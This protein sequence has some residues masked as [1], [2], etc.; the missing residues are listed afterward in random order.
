MMNGQIPRR[1]FKATKIRGKRLHV[2]PTA[3]SPI[4][5]DDDAIVDLD[6]SCALELFDR[7]SRLFLKYNFFL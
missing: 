7:S 1:L 3:S 6:V 2:P 4:R 5:V